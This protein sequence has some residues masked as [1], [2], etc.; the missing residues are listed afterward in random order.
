MIKKTGLL[1]VSPPLWN[2]SLIYPG[3]F[4]LHVEKLLQSPRLRASININLPVIRHGCLRDE[5]S[6]CRSRQTQQL[7]AER[8]WG[9]WTTCAET[10]PA[11]AEEDVSCFKSESTLCWSVCCGC[12]NVYF[13]SS[14]WLGCTQW[15]AVVMEMGCTALARGCKRSCTLHSHEIKKKNKGTLSSGTSYFC[16]ENVQTMFI[17][18]RPKAQAALSFQ[19]MNKHE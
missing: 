17:S 9:E 3:S 12:C 4:L 10:P 13:R 11:A 15:S 19:L 2:D 18:F 16:I 14:Y 8:D 7:R 6:Q 1:I 5:R